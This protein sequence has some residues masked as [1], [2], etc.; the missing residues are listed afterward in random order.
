MV[1]IPGRWTMAPRY[2]L[3]GLRPSANEHFNQGAIASS[4][5][6][7]FSAHRCNTGA[8]ATLHDAHHANGSHA[9]QSSLFGA[10]M[11]LSLARSAAF[12]FQARLP[13]ANDRYQR[14]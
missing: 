12:Y 9:H 5:A 6:P 4:T 8:C 10:A 2:R 11:A 13:W 7:L 3:K 14:G 1:Q